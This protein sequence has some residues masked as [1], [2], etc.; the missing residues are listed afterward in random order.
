MKFR[1]GG[2]HPRLF[3]PQ[4]RLILRIPLLIDTMELFRSP[5]QYWISRLL[6]EQIPKN[7]RHNL[8]PTSL[9]TLFDHTTKK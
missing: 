5:Y 8:C 2:P 3:V 4:D 6:C 9:P 7:L 1:K